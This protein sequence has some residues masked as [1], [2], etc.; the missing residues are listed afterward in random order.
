MEEECAD[1]LKILTKNRGM[2][3]LDLLV[4]SDSYNVGKYCN[5]SENKI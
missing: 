5:L 1:L 2:K 3:H 4:K